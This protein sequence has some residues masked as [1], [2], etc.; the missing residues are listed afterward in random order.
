MRD[1]LSYAAIGLV[2]GLLVATLL[3]WL[4]GSGLHVRMRLAGNWHSDLLPWLRIGGIGGAVAG[5]VLKERIG[6]LMGGAVQGAYEVETGARDRELP[7]WL[8]VLVL[9]GVALSVWYFLTH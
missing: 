9:A 6:D 8:I 2:L 1:R 5:F 4:H 7:A 3:W